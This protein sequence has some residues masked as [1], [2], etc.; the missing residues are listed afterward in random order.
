MSRQWHFEYIKLH[1]IC[2]CFYIYLPKNA[3]FGS[4]LYKQNKGTS[5]RNM[6]RSFPAAK[7]L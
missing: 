6:Q 2:V 5:C 3:V 1:S 7:P 4:S